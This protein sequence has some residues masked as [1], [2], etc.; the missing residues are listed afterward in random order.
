[1]LVVGFVV[2]SPTD[3]TYTSMHVQINSGGKYEQQYTV[4]TC[5]SVRQQAKSAQ[6]SD[7]TW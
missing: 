6:K 1:V 2:A 5:V 4:L 7:A 3:Q